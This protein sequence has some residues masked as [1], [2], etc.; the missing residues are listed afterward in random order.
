M[1]YTTKKEACGRRVR[2]V[3][4]KVMPCLGN[5]SH[6]LKSTPPKQNSLSTRVETWLPVVLG[7]EE[8]QWL[9]QFRFHYI[10]AAGV[11]DL[12]ADMY[13]KIFNLSIS[14]CADSIFFLP[15]VYSL[16]APQPILR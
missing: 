11:A 7:K 5:L 16:L 2:A 12:L 13:K 4:A 15:S 1:L 8:A 10:C 14:N 9:Y 3:T 6:G